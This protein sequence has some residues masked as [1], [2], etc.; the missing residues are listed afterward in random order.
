MNNVG[1]G[2]VFGR[3]F[4]TSLPNVVGEL[5]T[6]QRMSL[7]SM[8]YVEIRDAS[9]GRSHKPEWYNP[10]KNLFTLLAPS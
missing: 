4:E 8:P 5:R 6:F 7:E 10:P 2:M 9:E 3:N 1:Q